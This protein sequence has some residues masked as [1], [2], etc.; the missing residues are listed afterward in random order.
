MPLGKAVGC[1]LDL[2]TLASD[3][4]ELLSPVSCDAG[5]LRNLHPLAYHKEPAFPHDLDKTP[6]L[7]LDKPRQT[8]KFLFCLINGDE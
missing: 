8:F 5:R 2:Q 6:G 1:A 7:T 3:I 4:T